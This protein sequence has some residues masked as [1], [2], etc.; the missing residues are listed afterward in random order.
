M[1]SA[2]SL[3]RLLLSLVF[4]PLAASGALDA[5]QVDHDRRWDEVVVIAAAEEK[6]IV[7]FLHFSNCPPKSTCAAFIELAN[8]P[9][10]RRRMAG[11]LFATRE[12]AEGEDDSSVSVL[13]PDG[14]RIIRW[15]GIPD[16]AQFALML[17]GIDQAAPHIVAAYRATQSGCSTDATRETALAFLALGYEL[18]ARPALESLRDSGTP[19][20]RQLAT[21]WLE[22]L[23]ARRAKRL[24]DE[25]LLTK[26]TREGVTDRVRFE[27]WIA[28][29]DV[30]LVGLRADD[31]LAAYAAAVQLAP[32]PSPQRQLALDARQRAELFAAPVRGIGSPGSIVTGRRTIWP[33]LL[34]KET[35]RVEYRLDETLVATSKKV[36]FAVSIDFGRLPKRRMLTVTAF[37]DHGRTIRA[38]SSTVNDRA[39]AFA[40]DIVEPSSPDLSGTV[41][42]VVAVKVPQGRRIRSVIVEWDGRR[43]ARFEAPPYETTLHVNQYQQGVLRAVARLEDGSE[44]EDVLLVNSGSMT[45]ESEVHLVEVP[46]FSEDDAPLVRDRVKIRED[47]KTLPVDR[48]IPASDSPLLVAL[49]IDGSW[50]MTG[51]MLDVQEAAI[52][53]V[54][55]HVAPD[56]RVMVIGFDTQ[57]RILWPTSDRS[58]VE[59]AILSIQAQG[60]TSLNDAM[61]GALLQLQAPGWR[62]ALIVFSDGLDNASSFTAGDVGEVAKR[63]GVPV[64]V[65]SLQPEPPVGVPGLAMKS[66]HWVFAART[67]LMKLAWNSGGKAF[68]L[69]SLENLDAIWNEIGRDLGRQSLVV[70]QP[71]P[72]ARDWRAL[73][74]FDGARRLRAPSG[75]AVG[76][77]NAGASP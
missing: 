63:S 27:A 60:Y 45:L 53:F 20:D 19:E 38:S 73:E 74:V 4:V 50:S 23:D 9:A 14:T 21:I 28:L 24:P 35:T 66:A 46:V 54:E 59:H 31:A 51:N 11:I 40:I 57:L 62:R 52:R 33:R 65:M 43:I 25:A 72:G 36:P 32:D 47:G 49:L 77:G 67:E 64:Y 70:Y 16:A 15:Q 2:P 29:G 61:L 13:A 58:L 69:A 3:R 44:L 68:D 55:G 41:P 42:V 30:L 7:A 12:L 8:H 48:V 5:Q 6:P 76:A 56:D 71:S 34:P 26:L 75:L 17:T 39:D 22:R 1:R 37:G 18:K 10:N